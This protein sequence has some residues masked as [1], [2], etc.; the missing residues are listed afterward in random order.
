MGF[1]RT[2]KVNGGLEIATIIPDKTNSR[3]RRIETIPNEIGGEP[4]VSLG[5]YLFRGNRE[6]REVFVPEG[7]TTIRARAFANTRICKV[8]LP[9][10][11]NDIGDGA[12]SA[13]ALMEL[14]MAENDVFYYDE[15]LKT[16]FTD[17]GATIVE[18][19]N[20]RG[21]YVVPFGAVRARE[22]AFGFL[23]GLRSI[24]LSETFVDF[25]DEFPFWECRHL[26]RIEVDENNAH[27]QSIDG[28][29]FT[30]RASSALCCYPP[31]RKDARYELP[32]TTKRILGLPFVG[33]N[34]KT[35]ALG[36]NVDRMDANPFIGAESLE[37]IEVDEGNFHYKADDGVLR[38]RFGGELIAYPRSRPGKEYVAPED[39]TTIGLY[40]F[41]ETRNL[42]SVVFP[43][44]LSQID[45]GAFKRSSLR[46][47][48][49]PES[50]TVV[51]ES[52]C[53]ECKDL[54]SATIPDSVVM[55]EAD[56]FNGCEKLREIRLSN[57]LVSIGNRAFYRAKS[58]GDTRLPETLRRLGSRAFYDAGP[59]TVAL[60]DQIE[61]CDPCAFDQDKPI[62]VREDSPL[63]DW[64]F[65]RDLN[66]RF[67]AP[68]ED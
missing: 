31:G 45:C 44:T 29:L 50:L 61:E 42:Q 9:S 2:R 30:G 23:A 12:F 6:I 41:A 58:L 60:P 17:G 10:T 22:G 7:V 64:A 5:P 53:F 11:L 43:K 28:V 34:L 8:H 57:S 1:Y 13:N 40:A 39:I 4:V 15:N 24:F 38:D 36:P 48:E 54:K 67:K 32:A 21:D 19:V 49:F 37:R 59:H 63:H 55:I 47:I 20:F 18:C 14:E 51:E 65:E 46:S 26:E 52:V 3:D 68:R 56:A 35:I 62:L 16:I 25:G 27:F 66:F 33:S